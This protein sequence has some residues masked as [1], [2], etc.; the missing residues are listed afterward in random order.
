MNADGSKQHYIGIEA[1][2]CKWSQDGKR[3]IYVAKRTD[4]YDIYTCEIYGTNEK[5]LTSTSANEVFPVYSL[6]G[7][8]IA[9]CASTGVYG[10]P[11]NQRTYEIYVINSDGSGLSRLTENDDLDMYPRWSPD[12]SR[13]V[14][15]SNRH[16]FGQWEV[17][18]MDVDGTNIRRV[19]ISPPNI[20]AVNPVYKPIPKSPYNDVLVVDHSDYDGDGKSEIAVFGPETWIWKIKGY[21]DIKFGKKNVIPVPGD[22]NG[23]KKMD[24]AV[25]DPRRRYTIDDLRTYGFF[26]KVWGRTVLSK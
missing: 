23:D 20:T 15:S 13:L 11:E 3:F 25:Y 26:K 17:Y 21:S 8:Q 10:T 16:A 9:F 4:N 1:F 7:Y 24:V 2:G 18:V 5:Q 22:Y 6:D 19:T 12:G 14:F